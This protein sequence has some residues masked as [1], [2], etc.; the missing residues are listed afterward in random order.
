[1]LAKRQEYYAEED[2]LR[3]NWLAGIKKSWAEYGE[4]VNDINGQI[5]NIGM[6][7]LSG[8]SDQLTEF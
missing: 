7:A 6:S 2:R 8:L 1:M 5:E 4:T 3:G